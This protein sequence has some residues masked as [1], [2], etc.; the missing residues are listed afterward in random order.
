MRTP[1][2]ARRA[3][4]AGFTLIE[5]L[6]VILI[7]GILMTFL[8]P[9]VTAAVDSAQVLA[10][11]KNMQEIFGGL[12]QYQVHN[13]TKDCVPTESGV[14]FF[15]ALIA[16]GV[17]ENT[18][19]DG[20]KLTCPGVSIG[21]L[22]GLGN[23]PKEWFMHLDSVDGSYSAYAGRDQNAPGPA[24]GGKGGK[25]GKGDLCGR[26]GH[27]P[28]SGKQILI[29]DD[30]CSNLGKGNHRSTTVVLYASGDVSTFELMEL[31]KDGT[32]AA[33]E[34]V[35]S[36]GPDSPIEALRCLSVD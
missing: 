16:D 9:R 23:D 6:A 29:A 18:E 19:A 25:A 2:L 14:K 13:K 36:V 17:W 33:D 34:E 27:V 8:I 20:K 12:M 15:A 21:T 26:I 24:K 32:L 28:G 22:S 3:A 10:C 4:S 11:K 31:H 5:L 30:N 35:L 7:L 1:N